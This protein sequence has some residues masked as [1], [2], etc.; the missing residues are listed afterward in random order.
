MMTFPRIRFEPQPR[1]RILATLLGLLMTISMLAACASRAPTPAS[2]DAS[3]TQQAPT[4]LKYVAIGASDAFGVGTGD[5]DRDNWPTVLS[6]DLGG[7]VHLVNL[8][9]P[10]ITV[11]GARKEE[12]PVAVDAHPD[13]VTVWLAV[14]DMA[15]S[16]PLETYREQLNELLHSLKQNTHAR[17]FV[18]NL[19]DLTLLPY[20]SG[21]NQTV[22]RA[23]VQ[24]W[25]DT[26]AEV[27]AANGATLVDL[28]SGWQELATHPEYLAI[29]GL[30]PSTIGA[31]RLAALFASVIGPSL[32]LQGV[33]HP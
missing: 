19:P 3:T 2:N 18:G 27:A 16:V 4:T 23:T 12:L 33:R 8:G 17:I 20:F 32:A 5:P 29:D 15:A 22:L 21:A 10:G 9:I 24:A 31:R 6:H 30:H 7:S 1:H 25:N 13:V 26:I 28:Y 14:N 11:A